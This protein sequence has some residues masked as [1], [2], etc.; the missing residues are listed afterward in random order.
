MKLSHLLI[1]AALTC[2]SF[3]MSQNIFVHA[4]PGNHMEDIEAM[5]VSLDLR[6]DEM[7]RFNE[8]Q[9]KYYAD[10][11]NAYHNGTRDART[12]AQEIT[13]RMNAE[14]RKNISA[15]AY[16]RYISYRERVKS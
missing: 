9:D 13:A 5:A 4:K 3:A 14:I 10:I 2:G 1:A 7:A 8:L 16:E 12:R 11:Y 15:A 6:G